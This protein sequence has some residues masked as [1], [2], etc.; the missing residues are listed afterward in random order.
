MI[1]GTIAIVAAMI[2]LGVVVNRKLGIDPEQL[3]G[4][5]PLLTTHEIGESPATALRATDAQIAKLNL[6]CK[7]CRAVLEPAGV[8]DEVRYGGEAMRVLGYRCPQCGVKR[9]LYTQRKA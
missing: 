1:L 6:H 8:E 4:K 2:A 9:P 5:K 3:A 7:A